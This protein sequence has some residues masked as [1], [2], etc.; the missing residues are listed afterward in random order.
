MQ[1]VVASANPG[2]MRELN[3]RLQPLGIDLLSVAEFSQVQPDETGLTFVENAL[4]K[5]R[6]ACSISGLPA[7]ADDSGLLVD[8]LDSRPG[9]FS[10]RYAGTHASAADNCQKLL[11]ELLHVPEQQRGAQFFCALVVLKATNDPMP[12]ISTASWRGIIARHEQGTGG[13]GYDPIFYLPD[14]QCSAAELPPVVK[15]TISHRGQAI[16]RL[17]EQLEMRT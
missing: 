1:L 12:I 5:A 16:T 8:A 4:I 14:Y 13:F 2:K 10:A 3:A 9:I 6:H 11:Q 15:N 17:V 7:L